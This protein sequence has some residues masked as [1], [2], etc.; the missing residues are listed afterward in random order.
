MIGSSNFSRN[1]CH[2][3][4]C[5]RGV[6]RLAPCCC[7]LRATASGVRPP[8]AAPGNCRS[9]SASVR[10]IHPEKPRTGREGKPAAAPPLVSSP[11]LVVGQLLLLGERR[12]S[13][14]KLSQEDYWCRLVEK[15]T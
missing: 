11:S 14:T 12:G 15:K 1:F 9:I 8:T 10:M 5:G 2:N 13:M 4:S 7:R 6:R 3:G